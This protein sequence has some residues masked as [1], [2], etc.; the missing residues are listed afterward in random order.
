MDFSSFKQI[1]MIVMWSSTLVL[2]WI[3]SA[4]PRSP[5]SHMANGNLMFWLASSPPPMHSKS[6]DSSQPGKLIMEQTRCR[7]VWTR[8]NL[9]WHSHD[10]AAGPHQQLYPRAMFM[11]DLWPPQNGMG[12]SMSIIACKTSSEITA[13]T[14]R[15]FL[16]RQY[17]HVRFSTLKI[18]LHYLQVDFHVCTGE[19]TITWSCPLSLASGSKRILQISDKRKWGS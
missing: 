15:K 13:S 17:P 18:D 11:R 5:W 19:T 7:E 14:R 2:F 10:H 4:L 6:A 16:A 3:L 9:T 1:F 12:E 8:H